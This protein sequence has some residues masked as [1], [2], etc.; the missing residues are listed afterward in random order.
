MNLHHLRIFYTVA[1]RR[2]ITAAAGDLLLSQPAVSL[3]IKALE[4]ELGLAL[5]QRGG[6]R[7]SLTQ[8]GEVLYRSAVSILHAKDEAERAITE[9]RD[10]TKGRIIL[11]AGTTGGMY[12]LPR[13]V[14][15]YKALWPDTEILFHVGTTDQILE[16]LLQNVL[17]MG[18]VGGPVEDRRFVVEPVCSDELVLIAAPSHP[19]VA[20]GRVTLGDLDGVPFI[21]PETGSRTRLLVERKLREAGVPLRI[22]MQL[23]GTEGVKRAVEAG[24]GVGMVSRYS[25]ESEC[26]TGVLRPVPLQGWRL[27]RPMNLVYRAQKYFS[28]VGERF[29]EFAK[30]YGQAHLEPLATGG[31][32]GEAA[33]T[34]RKSHGIAPGVIGGVGT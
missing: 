8:A 32:R 23:P 3:Q 19:I 7:L 2:S 33:G 27:T 11:G 10:G 29:R 30:S 28:P 14:Q 5:F 15:A 9:L 25:V 26:Q 12:V 18:L 4:K 21:V 13:I 6:S 24:L 22:A 31:K 34:P 1:Q 16:K 17:D 20:L